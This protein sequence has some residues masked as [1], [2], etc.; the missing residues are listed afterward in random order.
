MS[1]SIYDLL[2]GV[3]ISDVQTAQLDS[4]ASRTYV[5]TS[6]REFWNP[7][8]LLSHVVKAARTYAYGLPIPE[9]GAV[10]TQ[11]VADAATATV[12]PTGTEIWRVEGIDIDSCSVGFYDGTTVCGI[13]TAQNTPP[14]FITNTN[15]LIFNNASGS[16]KNP[17][18]AY[19][20]VGL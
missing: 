3:K 5:D 17:D 12:Q 15:Y 10:W 4:A 7:I 18:V 19:S 20:K 9:L 1:T 13:D 16:A 11:E 6:T 8:L 2:T 14:Y